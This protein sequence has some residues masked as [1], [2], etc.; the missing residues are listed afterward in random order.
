MKSNEGRRE[1]GPFV[2]DLDRQLLWKGGELLHVPAK[3]LLLLATFVRRPG[4]LLGKAEIFQTVWGETVVEENTLARRVAMLRRILGET[5]ERHYIVTFHGYGYRFVATVVTPERIASSDNPT[6][7]QAAEELAV[8]VGAVEASP[9]ALVQG[10]KQWRLWETRGVAWIPFAVVVLL[11]VVV[12][13]DR[14]DS[15]TAKGTDRDLRQVTYESGLQQQPAWSPDGNA[16]A[17][18]ADRSGNLDIW[19]RQGDSPLAVALTNSPAHESQP[20]WSPD[21]RFV[22]F[23]SEVG[24]GGLFVIPI[25]G[26][27]ARQLTSFGYAPRWS[28]TG[29]WILFSAS[30]LSGGSFSPASF[31]V[32]PAGGVPVSVLPDSVAGWRSSSL[33]WV[34]DETIISVFGYVDGEPRFVT[35]AL[36][37][38]PEPWTIPSSVI[39][40]LTSADVHL[41][42]PVWSP[43]RSFLYFVGGQGST[44]NVWRVGVDYARRR[45]TGALE[46]LTMGSGLEQD[47]AVSPDGRQLA[48]SSRQEGRRLWAL[49]FDSASARIGGP[50]RPLTS[51]E[52]GDEEDPVASLDGQ[53][54][55]FRTIRDGRQDIRHV[56]LIDGS[57]QLLLADEGSRRSNPHWSRDGSRLVYTR[58]RTH[59]SDSERDLIVMSSSGGPE[60]IVATNLLRPT[61]WAPDG[62]AIL[63]GCKAGQR[64]LPAVCLVALT[65]GQSRSA[66]VVAADQQRPLYV[67]RF[68]PDQKW[69]GFIAAGSSDNTSSTVYVTRVEGGPWTAID[70]GPGWNDKVR[71]TN[72]GRTLL[73]VSDRAGLLNVW[74]R[75]FDPIAGS[76]SGP[77]FRVTTLDNP[78]QGL[79]ASVQGLEVAITARDLVV[80]INEAA[81]RVWVLNGLE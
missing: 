78:R 79:P 11:A 71:W 68:S 26:G 8:A 32:D 36:D 77:P 61:D 15:G 13:W 63:G 57:E 53:G 75:R 22:A 24:T 35:A 33:A 43:S 46:R 5:T 45:W 66:S 50:G 6:E 1:F 55:V 34:P 73:W 37:A 38:E 23:R 51:G 64:N 2:L 67:P 74:G 47:L 19:I 9:S 44:R 14:P 30:N 52:N 39:T 60:E 21:G 31:I 17:Y 81:G 62:Q 28:S 58:S 40:A 69:I 54:V 42:N 41:T 29:D 25:A 76:P 49:P 10:P 59:D 72:D 12:G 20:A 65:T 4:E 3:T 18:A 16:L 56:S 7:R 70:E 27:P 80:P 48:F